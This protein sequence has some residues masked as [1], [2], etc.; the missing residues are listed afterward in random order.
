VIAAIPADVDAVYVALGGADGVNFLTQYQQAGGTAP[1]IGGSITADQTVLSSQG[2]QKE[3]V[4]GMPSAGP[5]A[6]TWDDP[7]WTDFVAAYKAAFPDGFPSPSL[8]AHG[9]FVNTKAVLLALDQVNGDISDGGAKFR[10]ALAKLEFE[11]PTGPVKLDENR[12]AIAN[13]FVTEVA[14]GDDGNLYNKVVEVREGVNQT[15]GQ[16]VEE[17]LAL[18][19]VGRDNPH[20]P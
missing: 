6:D 16:S 3:A 7:R 2:K 17:F 8:F 20:C 15:L 19:V 5:V 12:N 13:I 18:G 14:V 4:T 9:Y 11:T 1:L 10:E